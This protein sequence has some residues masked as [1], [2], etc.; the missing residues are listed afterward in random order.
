MYAAVAVYPNGARVLVGFA[1]NR[2]DVNGLI[3]DCI[4]A[5]CRE[6]LQA[7]GV[8]LQVELAG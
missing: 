3:C 4:A 5:N 2:D 1:H 8:R 6:N 7:A